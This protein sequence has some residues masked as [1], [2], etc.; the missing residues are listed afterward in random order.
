MAPLHP[1][2]NGTTLWPP[3]EQTP[4]TYTYTDTLAPFPCCCVALV[5]PFYY[6][7]SFRGHVVVVNFCA[8]DM[9]RYTGLLGLPGSM[10]RDLYEDV[11]DTLREQLDADEE[12]LRKILEV[13]ALCLFGCFLCLF[14]FVCGSGFESRMLSCSDLSHLRAVCVCE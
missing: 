7:L 9:R 1:A 6:P 10:P 2:A 3:S 5:V 11:V 13:C 8:V 14:G 4:G 12:R